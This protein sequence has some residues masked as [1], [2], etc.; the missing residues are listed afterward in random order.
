MLMDM[1]TDTKFKPTPPPDTRVYA[2]GDIHGRLDLLDAL[3]AQIR[4]DANAMDAPQRLVLVLLGDLIDRGPQSRGVV[5]RT[6]DLT[7]GQILDDFEVHALMGNH[8]Q[9]MLQFLAGDNDGASWFANGGRETLISY[10]I[11]VKQTGKQVPDPRLRHALLEAL[12][13]D[14]RRLLRGMNLSHVEGDYAFVH[15]GVRPGVAWDEQDA[16]D[17]LWIRRDFTDSDADFGYFVV[18]GHSARDT[19]D[20][21]ANRANIDTRAWSSGVL[22]CLVLQDET[23]R[24]L[25]T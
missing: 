19:P 18:H 7:C 14:H 10:G 6:L 17:L 15:A 25:T 23:R 11:K 12:P 16:A 22:T 3:V 13:Q 9:A 2:I 24:F 20:V 21:R 1:K 5:Q 8:E 4:L